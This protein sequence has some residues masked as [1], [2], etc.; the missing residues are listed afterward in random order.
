M[1]MDLN[2]VKEDEVPM[3]ITWPNV[4][5]K[6]KTAVKKIASALANQSSEDHF[7]KEIME[8]LVPVFNEVYQLVK[9][10]V[11]GYEDFLEQFPALHDLKHPVWANMFDAVPFNAENNDFSLIRKQLTDMEV[12]MKAMGQNIPTTQDFIKVIII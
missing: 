4:T 2:N 5:A 10:N 12:R 1:S 6:G 3:K 9:T 11:A 7:R 8:A